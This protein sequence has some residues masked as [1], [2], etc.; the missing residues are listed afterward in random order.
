M[1]LAFLCVLRW[2]LQLDHEGTIWY[3]TAPRWISLPGHIGE[4]WN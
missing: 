1:T 2:I 4:I 3:S